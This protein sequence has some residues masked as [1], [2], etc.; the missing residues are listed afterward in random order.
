M[1]NKLGVLGYPL[2][3]TLS[4]AMQNAA[5]R[6]LGRDDLEYVILEKD[7]HELQ[8]AIED[9]K[10]DYLGIN[11]TIPYKEKIMP[12]IQ[13]VSHE[14]RL[15][16]AINTILVKD[17]KLV[18]TNTDG[19]GYLRSLREHDIDLKG[20]DILILGAGGASRGVATALA[21]AG[22][23]RIDICCRKKNR[24]R[25][26]LD[27]LTSVCKIEASWIDFKTLNKADISRYALIINTTP[28]GM[29]PNES[30]T[31]PFPYEKLEKHQILS[32]LIYRPSMTKFLLEGSKRGLTVVGGL[33]MLLYQ[34]A[35]SLAFWLDCDPPIEVMRESLLEALS[36]E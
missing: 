22:V 7:Y 9:I 13:E 20:K 11:V 17:D 23:S 29:Y 3:H 28:V 18:G 24:G 2:G 30:E 21:G 31:I 12:W 32:D 6:A 33:E 34:G 5:L 14:A 25:A 35:E 8:K 15:A 19:V 1:R 16:G 36:K 4:P 26:L 10:Q 27:I